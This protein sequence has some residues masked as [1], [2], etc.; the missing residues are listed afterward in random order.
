M[1]TEHYRNAIFL[2]L[3]TAVL[4]AILGQYTNIDLR[5]EDYYY[6]PQLKNFTWKNAWFTKEFMHTYLKDAIIAFGLVLLM[7]TISDAVRNWRRINPFLRVRLRFVAAGAIVIPLVISLLKKASV[8][9][10]PWDVVRYGG[11]APFV[12]LFDPV[13][14]TMEAGQCF[15]AGHASTALW[16]AA[17]CVFWLPHQPKKAL[18]VFLAGLMFGFALGWAQQMRGAHFLFHTLWALWLTG[19]LVVMMLAVSNPWLHKTTA[20]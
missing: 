10:C 18:M 20:I 1:R 3:I 11:N 8:L 7:V 19:A 4:I 12:R 16:L 9:H 6:D 2:L 5:I 14:K 13:T 17:F 15:P